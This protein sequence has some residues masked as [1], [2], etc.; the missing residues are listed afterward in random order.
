MRFELAFDSTI[1]NRQ[2]Q[3]IFDEVWKKS[4][5]KNKLNVV[6][7]ITLFIGGG[8][9]LLAGSSLGYLFVSMGLF[10][11]L[12]VVHVYSHFRKNQKSIF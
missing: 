4:L 10:Y 6:V 11:L 8:W 5:A 9:M 2:V 12:N 3:L 7:A 1:H